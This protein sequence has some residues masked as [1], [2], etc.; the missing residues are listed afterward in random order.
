LGLLWTTLF[1]SQLT[2]LIYP[3]IPDTSFYH[4]RRLRTVL[5]SASMPKFMS[6]VQAFVCSR[7]DYC[8]ALLIGLP[9]IRLAPLQS[10]LNAA[11]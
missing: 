8:N 5:R 6:M 10:V 4:L 9:N 11:H 2:S 7:D 3:E 1:L